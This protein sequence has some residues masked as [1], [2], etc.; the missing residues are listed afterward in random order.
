VDK[1]PLTTLLALRR[2]EEESAEGRWAGALAALKAAEATLAAHDAAV[3]AA[4]A[5][6]TDARDQKDPA[7][8]EVS[9]SGTARARANF[10]SR[11]RDELARVEAARTTFRGGPL[12]AAR[13]DEARAGRARLE[14]RQA[15]EVVERHEERFAEAARRTA[16][17]HAEEGR[18]EVASANR[19]RRAR[20]P[21]RDA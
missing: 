10:L 6:L 20:D 16:E 12:A 18:D 9:S 13:A 1:Y 17:K 5:R 11:R 8:G 15:R 3:A 19:H 21:D 14:K 2:A 7:A 4:E